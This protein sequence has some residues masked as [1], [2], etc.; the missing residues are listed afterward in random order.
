MAH[1]V[2]VSCGEAIQ[3]EYGDK[4]GFHAGLVVDLALSSS[5]GVKEIA[6]Y[7]TSEDYQKNNDDLLGPIRRSC[8]VMGCAT[9]TASKL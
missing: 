6:D 9:G 2:A 8:V 5:D 7:A 4:R 3:W 1:C